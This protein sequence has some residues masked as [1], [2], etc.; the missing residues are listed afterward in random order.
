MTHSREAIAQAFRHYQSEVAGI[1][2]TGE[3]ARFADLF[4]ED[5]TYEEH[6]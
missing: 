3:W 1:A 5:A 2:A 4:T 6:A